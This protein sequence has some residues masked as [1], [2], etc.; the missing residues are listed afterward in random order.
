MNRSIL[1]IS[2]VLSLFF[3][4]C[5]DDSKDSDSFKFVNNSDDDIMF[6]YG[7]VSHYTRK[8]IRPYRETSSEYNNLLRNGCIPAHSYKHFDYMKK[9]VY[10]AFES[11][12]LFIAVFNLLDYDTL[13][14]EEFDNKYPI[15]HE[16]QV[17]L[18]DLI[19]C[20]WTLV[21]PP[22]EQ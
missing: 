18:Q 5:F 12:T 20:D 10:E 11:D 22:D 15:K 13:S 21:F 1:F 3:I 19:D 2:I 16:Y 6:V 14:T 9:M 17:T 8:M 4:S 7:K